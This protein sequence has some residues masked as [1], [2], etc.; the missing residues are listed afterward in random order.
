MEREKE[1]EQRKSKSLL[2][3]QW[4]EMWFRPWALG[5]LL[6]QWEEEN[7]SHSQRRR[8]SLKEM[9]KNKEAKQDNGHCKR[10]ILQ[11]QNEVGEC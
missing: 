2:V 4:V 10:Y 1:R 7:P 9:E 5:F 6:N 11:G 3:S 8:H